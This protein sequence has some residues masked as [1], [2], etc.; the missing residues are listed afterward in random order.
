MQ[1]LA[2]CGFFVVAGGCGPGGISGAIDGEVVPGFASASFGVVTAEGE[3][4]VFGAA[5]PGDS[6]LDGAAVIDVTLNNADRT[7]EQR[8]ADDADFIND[9]VPEGSWYVLTEFIAARQADIESD[10]ID[11]SDFDEGVDFSFTVCFQDNEASADGAVL[12][13]GADCYNAKDGDLDVELAGDSSR[14]RVKGDDIEMQDLDGEAQGEVNIDLTF[15]HCPAMDT[16][17]DD[18]VASGG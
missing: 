2:L 1:K 11:L 4:A 3:G 10:T 17:L 8:A 5:L 7:P 13:N 15:S 18:L 12:D 6:C 16:A 14:Y 9:S